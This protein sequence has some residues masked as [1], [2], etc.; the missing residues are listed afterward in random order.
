[1]SIIECSLFSA[2]ITI[3]GLCVGIATAF[4][5]REDLRSIN[6]CSGRLKELMVNGRIFDV[7]NGVPAWPDIVGGGKDTLNKQSE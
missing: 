3:N 1:M 7:G 2:S 6:S 5:F 4:Y